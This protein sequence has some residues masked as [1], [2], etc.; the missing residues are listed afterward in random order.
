VKKPS[1]LPLAFSF[2][3]AMSRKDFVVSPANCEALDFIESWPNWTVAIAALYGPPGC[4]KTHL[5]SIWQAMTGARRISANE[6][7]VTELRRPAALAIEDIDLAEPTGKRDSALFAAMQTAGPQA[8][9][10]LTGSAPP[11]LWPCVLPDLASRFSAMV[12]LPVRAPDD[13]LLAGLA[14]KLFADRQLVVAEEVIEQMLFVLERSPA[15]VRTF[16]AEADATALSEARP[17]NLSLVR[18]LLTARQGS[19]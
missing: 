14:R 6:V 8:P 9:L 7:S 16:V 13:S 3:P 2:P 17:V 1:Q 12:A 15:S 5:A 19:S 18:R 11:P 10:L 4:G